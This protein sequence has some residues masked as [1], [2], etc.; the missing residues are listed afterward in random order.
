MVVLDLAAV[1]GLPA[2][3]ALV[4]EGAR[5]LREAGWLAP[6]GG[7]A[8][9]CAKAEAAPRWEC[10]TLECPPCVLT[11]PEVP[12]WQ[13]GLALFFAALGG[14]ACHAAFRRYGRPRAAPVRRGGGVVA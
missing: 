2:W 8:D 3:A 9:Q 10:P 7:T 5:L 4:V 1:R 14:A 13:I 6:A 11:C 12:F